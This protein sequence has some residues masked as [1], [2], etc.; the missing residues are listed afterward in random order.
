M[1]CKNC[2]QEFKRWVVIDGKLRNLSNRKYCLIC[3]PFGERNTS[4]HIKPE[5]KMEICICDRCN[6]EY[7]YTRSRGDTK[8]NCAGCVV[9]IKRRKVKNRAIDYKGGKCIKCGYHKCNRSLSFHHVDQSEKDFSVSD[10]YFWSWGRIEK[11]LDKCVLVCN[12][13]HGEI[14]EK[15]QEGILARSRMVSTLV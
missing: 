7:T 9:A 2:G 6:K 12:N 8:S 3:S 1:D 10:F 4:N 5:R 14:H 15:I 13:C 11:E